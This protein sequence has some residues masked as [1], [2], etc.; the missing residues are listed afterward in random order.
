LLHATRRLLAYATEP[1]LLALHAMLLHAAPS[2]RQRLVGEETYAT[3]PCRATEHW[4][5]PA[6]VVVWMVT[7]YATLPDIGSEDGE[8]FA[9]QATASMVNGSAASTQMSRRF[10]G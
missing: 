9:P 6:G 10:I 4:G 3:C 1:P 7:A 8:S 5:R 2:Q